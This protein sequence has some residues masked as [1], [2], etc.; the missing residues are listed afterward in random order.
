MILLDTDHLSVLKYDEH[1]R[2]R[3]L[4]AR[5]NASEDP[6]FATTIRTGDQGPFCV[7]MALP[8][9]VLAVRQ[10]VFSALA[11]LGAQLI[12]PACLRGIIGR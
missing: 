10:S 8:G 11:K 12:G 1:P 4:R 3:A 7:P 6:F 5:M 9:F 2:C